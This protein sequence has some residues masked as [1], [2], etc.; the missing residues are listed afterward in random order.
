MCANL[1]EPGAHRDESSVS[2]R[3]VIKGLKLKRHSRGFPLSSKS[4]S[5]SVIGLCLC[6]R[7]DDEKFGDWKVANKDDEMSFRMATM[8]TI[9]QTL[10][11]VQ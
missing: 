6:P 10:A 3:T 8:T 7:P 9:D 11:I 5:S 2:E 4:S 1:W